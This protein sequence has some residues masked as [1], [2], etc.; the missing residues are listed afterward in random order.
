MFKIFN[1][2]NENLDIKNSFRSFIK[3]AV[4]TI[5]PN[6]FQIGYFVM[7][8][9]ILLYFGYFITK[10]SSLVLTCLLAMCSLFLMFFT[11]DFFEEDEKKK[12]SIFKLNRNCLILNVFMLVN[13]M[14]SILSKTMKKN[15]MMNTLGTNVS[16]GGVSFI[17]LIAIDFIIFFF[18]IFYL[19]STEMQQKLE[20]YYEFNFWEY[21]GLLEE[22]H[23]K[24]GDIFICN[25]AV[26]DRPIRLPYTDRFLHMLIIGPTG[27]GKTSQIITPMLNQDVRNREAGVTVEF[28]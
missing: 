8:I 10:K 9:D 25:A 3:N 15:L 11:K 1:F 19:N 28:K 12:K 6:T 18:V 27:C 7:L 5:S 4:Q 2:N 21:F 14:A 20:K 24:A 23:M 16:L 17:V 22:E 13:H 26:D